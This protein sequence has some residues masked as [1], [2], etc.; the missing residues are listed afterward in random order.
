MIR[1]LKI[2]GEKIRFVTLFILNH[3]KGGGGRFI[4]NIYFFTFLFVFYVYFLVNY[5][6]IFFHLYGHQQYKKIFN[7]ATL[8]D[9]LL[10]E[11]FKSSGRIR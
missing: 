10:V 7:I 2:E 5:T 8:F 9:R 4:T 3:K 11:T 1:I 6:P